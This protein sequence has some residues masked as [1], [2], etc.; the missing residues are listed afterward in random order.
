MVATQ[1]ELP[2]VE[3]EKIPALERLIKKYQEY[4]LNRMEATKYEVESKEAVMNKMHELGLAVYKRPGKFPFKAVLTPKGETLKVEEI[5]EDE[6]E[7][8]GSQTE[9]DDE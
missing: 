5:D 2:G 9:P 3:Q 6:D 4:K 1:E 8:D 7:A